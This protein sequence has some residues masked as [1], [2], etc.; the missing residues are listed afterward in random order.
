MDKLFGNDGVPYL[1]DVD[2][3]TVCP[4]CL[5]LFT[6]DFVHKI[7]SDVLEVLKAHYLLEHRMFISVSFP[8][9]V[10]LARIVVRTLVTGTADK[11]FPFPSIG[12]LVTRLV[13]NLVVNELSIAS[14][15]DAAIKVII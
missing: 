5:G 10:D 15:S 14:L 11:S 2:S 8:P 13:T 4:S 9:L 3:R 12:D 6:T 1:C 7:A